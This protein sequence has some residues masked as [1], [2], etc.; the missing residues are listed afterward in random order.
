MSDFNIALTVVGGTALIIGM[1]SGVI[2]NRL[3]VSIPLIALIIGII[4]GKDGLGLLISSDWC[5]RYVMLEEGARVTLAVALMSVAMRLPANYVRNHWRPMMVLLMLVMP[6]MFVVSG[7]LV[8]AVFGVPILIALLIGAALTPTDPVVASA[9][10]TGHTAR[11]LIPA[12]VRDLIS[13]ESGS[14][15]G[16]AYPLLFIPL[17]LL[18]HPPQQALV[19]WVFEVMLWQVG[20]AA[21][22]GILIG[23]STAKLLRISERHDAIEN[24][25]FLGYTIAVSLL[26]L[27]AAKLIGSDGIFAVFVAG[28]MLNDTVGGHE[29]AREEKVQE[30]VDHFFV[31]PV[32]I[33]LGLELPWREWFNMGWQAVLIVLLLTLLRRLPALLVLGGLLSPLRT[34]KDQLF[35]GWFGPLGVAALYYITYALREVGDERIWIIGTLLVCVS[36]LIHGVTATPFT[37]WYAQGETTEPGLSEH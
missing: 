10:V 22:I 15:D 30:A 11:A 26:A 23:W 9:I 12:R 5:C 8:Y 16:L 3:Y 13:A 4:V 28:M 21:V 32:F 17:L 37:N 29:R 18:S 36:I 24:T 7:V 34:R 1:F 19:K 20:M 6:F 33:L 14:N 35:V 25:Y 27:S 2:K 31:I